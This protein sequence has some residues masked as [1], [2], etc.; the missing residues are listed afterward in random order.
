MR[1]VAAG[2]GAVLL[3]ASLVAC[4]GDDGGETGD[5]AST[6]TPTATRS[7]ER[8]LP[9]PKDDTC[10]RIDYD[11]AV[12][13]TVDDASVGCGR[14]H[15]SRTIAVTPLDATVAG[16]FLAVDSARVRRQPVA[17]CRSAFADHVGGTEE[18]RRLTMLTVAVFSPSLDDSDLGASWVR[19]DLVAVVAPEKLGTLPGPLRGVL[20]T[21][22]GR[23]RF[24]MCGT[25]KPGADDFTRVA[26]SQSHSWRAVASVD[27]PPGPKGSWPGRKAAQAAGQ[28]PCAEAARGNADDALSY[29]WGYEWPDRKQ[30]KAGRTHGFC[31]APD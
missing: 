10:H 21:K 13:M 8:P 6:A 29:D 19:C 17:T 11:Q 31:W 4:S 1:R 27:V 22:D 12:E 3:T 15:T 2:I 9:A 16:H 7:A 20:D 30:W 18:Q 14:P 24:G 25:A 5:D 23:D 28:K 26:C